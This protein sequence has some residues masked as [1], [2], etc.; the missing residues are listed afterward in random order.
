MKQL[1]LSVFAL[2]LFLTQTSLGQWSDKLHFTGKMDGAQAGVSTTAVGV[3]S[4]SYNATMDTACIDISVNGLSGA[5]TGIHIHEGAVGV[6]GG[7]V[8]NLGSFMNGN[9]ITGKITTGLD[10]GKLMKGMYY[11]NVHTTLNS[12]GEIRGQ[13]WPE[14]DYMYRAWMD[15]TYNNPTLAGGENPIGLATFRLGKDKKMMHVRC[16]ANDLT[17]V[18]NSAHLH[19][20]ALGMSGGVMVNLTSMINGNT[21]VGSFDASAVTGLWDSLERGSIYLNVHTTA[22]PGGEIRGQLMP[23]KRL[24][25][26]AW[27]DTAQQTQTVIATGTPVGLSYTYFSW[28]L[29]TM[30]Y[31]LV[32]D[33]LTG[34]ISS[35]HVHDGIFGVSGGV[36]HSL[37]GINGNRIQGMVTGLSATDA[38]K[39][40]RGETY[41]NVHTAANAAGEIRGQIYKYAR[42]GY[43][44]WLNGTQQSPSVAVSGM[45]SGIV[46]V[47]RDKTNAHVMV[48]VS[49]LTGPA[50]SAHF[51]NAAFGV[52]GPPVYTL[53]SWF[54]LAGTDD[55][56]F[57]YWTS[58]DA[59]TPFTA[60]HATM[61]WTGDMYLNVHTTANASGE[62]RGQVEMGTYCDALSTSTEKLESIFSQFEIFPNPT[63][64]IANVNL[65]TDR[66]GD[67]NINV[68]NLLG[69]TLSTNNVTFNAGEN[70]FDLDL[71][72][73][74]N[75]VYFVTLNA[76]D[77]VLTKK[78]IKQ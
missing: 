2:C 29:D 70:R 49:G 30:W 27:L 4:L 41:V 7:V 10:W 23:E 66:T 16:V 53:S 60:T 51:H 40:L 9:R 37:T 61:F 64:G 3:V 32:A 75:G 14:S 33:G 57:G 65:H 17:G 34:T 21:I 45:G 44:M 54:G 26:D 5:I 50:I 15:T 28:S 48:V 69:E 18:I 62:I 77:Q 76:G 12:N 35:S 8:V 52:N 42:N 39:M 55:S 6:S 11:V 25:F 67:Y 59:V 46:S 63:T 73:Y 22:N 38:A 36:L 74:S 24:A 58:T 71:S 1:F 47:D 78:I 31:D 68:Y 43:N 56:A 13:I 20:G 72:S 19:M